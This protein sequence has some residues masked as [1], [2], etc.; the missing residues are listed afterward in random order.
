MPPYRSFSAL[1][2][3]L[4]FLILHNLHIVGRHT[5]ED[6]YALF[7][8]IDDFVRHVALDYD[9]VL[10]LRDKTDLKKEW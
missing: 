4:L 10:A 1:V 6:A 2:A 7:E 5:F 9:L 8:H 3:S